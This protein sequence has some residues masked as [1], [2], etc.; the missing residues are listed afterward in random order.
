[1]ALLLPGVRLPVLVLAAGAVDGLGR[2]STTMGWCPMRTNTAR[3][4]ERL[5]PWLMKGLAPLQLKLGTY[6]LAQLLLFAAQQ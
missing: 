4:K 3:V 2:T 5:C 6:H 1:M